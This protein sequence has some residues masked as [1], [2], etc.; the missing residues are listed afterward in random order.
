MLS[1]RVLAMWCFLNGEN[2]DPNSLAEIRGN[3]RRGLSM[4]RLVPKPLLGCCHE[5]PPL[6]DTRAVGFI[7]ITIRSPPVAR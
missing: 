3:G 1:M 6:W 2:P 5:V 4:R 7:S